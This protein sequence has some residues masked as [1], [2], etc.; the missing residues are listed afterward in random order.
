M[1]DLSEE[2]DGDFDWVQA[3]IIVPITFVG[4]M[5]VTFCVVGCIIYAFLKK[6]GF[7]AGFSSR[8]KDFEESID[9]KDPPAPKQGPTD[10][11]PSHNILFLS[12]YELYFD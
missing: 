4:G 9:T 12:I 7:N 2:A 3:L 5:V 1:V 6:R 11:F 8:M 10:C